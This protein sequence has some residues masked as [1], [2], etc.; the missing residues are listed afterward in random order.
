[1]ITNSA[2]TPRSKLG[3]PI[4]RVILDIGDCYDYTNCYPGQTR[5]QSLL[6]AGPVHER[7]EG[8]RPGATLFGTSSKQDETTLARLFCG[9]IRA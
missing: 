5:Y 2:H 3:L 4:W 1:M 6:E 7:D 9:H 8:N